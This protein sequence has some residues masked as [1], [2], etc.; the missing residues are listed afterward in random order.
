M[1][2]NFGQAL[3]GAARR[4]SSRLREME[5]RANLVA[6]RAVNRFMNEHDEWKRNYDVDLRTY[7]DA[8]DKLT[9]LNLN[10]V[11]LDDGQKEMILL[12]GPN[13]ADKFIAAYEDDQKRRAK[14]YAE[15]QMG[16][17][18]T[19]TPMG[20]QTKRKNIPWGP[21]MYTAAMTKDFINRT[22]TRTS[23]YQAAMEDPTNPKNQAMLKSVGLGQKKASMA[24]AQGKNPYID[25][26]GRTAMTANIEESR[27]RGI[28][29]VTIPR[30]YIQSTIRNSL[31]EAGIVAPEQ[32]DEK[33]GT[34]T[35]WNAPVYNALSLDDQMTIETHVLDKEIQTDTWR[36]DQEKHKWAKHL[37]KFYVQEAEHKASL[38]SG[39]KKLQEMDIAK[40]KLIEAYNKVYYDV[41][42][43]ETMQKW[44]TQRAE[45][46]AKA[47]KKDFEK[48]D[49]DAQILDN[50]ILEIKLKEQLEIAM[51]NNDEA[52]ITKLD[53]DIQRVS[54]AIRN[55][56]IISRVINSTADDIIVKTNQINIV[57]TSYLDQTYIRLGKNKEPASGATT[58]IITAPGQEPPDDKSGQNYYLI[59]NPID[60]TLTKFYE[61]TAEYKEREKRAAQMANKMVLD[62]LA[63]ENAD[64]TFTNKFEGDA[65]VDMILDAIRK[66]PIGP[67]TNLV[68]Y[69]NSLA[70]DILPEEVI[71][72]RN[73][74]MAM[75][76]Y[77]SVHPLQRDPNVPTEAEIKKIMVDENGALFGL[78]EANELY[79]A[80]VAQMDGVTDKTETTEKA[81]SEVKFETPTEKEKRLEEEAF[82]T[83]LKNQKEKAL[84]SVAETKKA[85]PYLN[86]LLKELVENKNTITKDELAQTLVQA[87]M[88]E[89]NANAAIIKWLEENRNKEFKDKNGQL[90]RLFSPKPVF[91]DTK[92]E[93]GGKDDI[94]MDIIL[95]G[96][97]AGL[98]R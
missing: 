91:E 68:D 7:N 98:F 78:E 54:K 60:N 79:D 9:G 14:E 3:A 52:L 67:I 97:K 39:E 96:T 90:F 27:Q 23:D 95:P 35:G 40:A 33:L 17:F 66:D 6:D 4:G 25:I 8:W 80:I 69:Q 38:F 36:M 87:G 89:D 53:N 70:K 93:F 55:D 83:D 37:N 12:G 43:A 62:M 46:E 51:A 15:S 61:G 34:N 31:V 10:G 13:G 58:T 16:S 76:N 92:F 21:T 75:R 30:S 28:L 18:T 74:I 41:R 82:Q 85:A 94:V 86:Y 71:K 63:T 19:T 22:F 47:A 81:I 64:G 11:K 48:V 49:L 73:A 26:E 88:L 44:A 1:R 84:K 5:D 59:R 45:Y 20:V 42:N 50:T 24:Y 2:F 72:Y 56:Q 65:S 32:I 77:S 29:G 57:R